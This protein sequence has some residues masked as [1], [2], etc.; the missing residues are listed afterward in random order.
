[1]SIKHIMTHSPVTVSMDDPLSRV[2]EIFDRHGFHHVLVVE[3]ERLA[4]V[5]SDRDLLKALSPHVGTASET[6]RD[7]ASLRKRAHQIM[8]RKLITLGVDARIP[9]AIEVFHTHRISC[10]P[11][12]DAAGRPI[13]IVSWRDIMSAMHRSA[14]RHSRQAK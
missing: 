2:K 12:V 8:S 3:G 10:I 7:L 4:G 14:A 9:D 13:G 11:I 5:I 1:M 6:T